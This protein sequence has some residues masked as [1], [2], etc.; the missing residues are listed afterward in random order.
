MAK[1]E[2]FIDL[3]DS[4]VNLLQSMDRRVLVQ[5]L[6]RVVGFDL[7]ASYTVQERSLVIEIPALG[8]RRK[9]RTADLA[10]QVRGDD[11]A[12]VVTFV[13]E[14]Q[15]TYSS[16]K[17]RDWMIFAVAFADD[18][19]RK[20][21]VVV[22]A[23]K[24]KLRRKIRRLIARIDEPVYAFEPDH[25]ERID[26]DD[27]AR[28]RPHE[29]ILGAL[30]HSG[31]TSLDPE[32]RVASVRA[33]LTALERLE[34]LERLDHQTW[35]G[36]LGLIMST[37]PPVIGEPAIEAAIESGCID[38]ARLAANWEYWRGGTLHEWSKREGRAEGLEEGLAQGFEEGRERGL[39]EGRARGLE[40]G[41]ARGIEAGRE[42]GRAEALRLVIA[43][44]LALHDLDT[45]ARLARVARCDDPAILERWFRALASDDPKAAIAETLDSP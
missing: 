2:T 42:Q 17:G 44:F 33:A 28:F 7:P 30:F 14:V 45:K 34:R 41:R 13:I 9:K 25:I 4:L 27:L 19:D 8:K 11:D 23:P 32:L 36:Y 10:L 18:L 38:A 37:A 43:K 21:R 15:Q 1:L 16:A 5:L 31:E 6:S 20:A 39:E 29:T 22:V 35:L 26:D 12:V 40:E 24:P 3:H